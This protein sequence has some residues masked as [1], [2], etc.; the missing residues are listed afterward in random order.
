MLNIV[1]HCKVQQ[2]ALNKHKILS[3]VY[4]EFLFFS[5]SRSV[6]LNCILLCIYPEINEWKRDMLRFTFMVIE[7]Q[8]SDRVIVFFYQQMMNR[9]T[10]KWRNQLQAYHFFFKQKKSVKI[11][12]HFTQSHL[13]K[14]QFDYHM[15][16]KRVCTDWSL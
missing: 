6:Q 10:T 2:V 3:V 7:S 13:P 15:L 12:S 4:V 8:T 16:F 11:C 1:R 9:L 14:S 5:L